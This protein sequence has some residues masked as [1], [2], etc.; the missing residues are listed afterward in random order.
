MA[1]VHE[2]RAQTARAQ[3]RECESAGSACHGS[4][5]FH[6][7]PTPCR[8]SRGPHVPS[9]SSAGLLVARALQ[10]KGTEERVSGAPGSEAVQKPRGWSESRHSVQNTGSR[11]V[12]PNR[13]QA[14]EM[15]LK[16]QNRTVFVGRTSLQVRWTRGT[17]P[18]PQTV[19]SG[20]VFTISW[21]TDTSGFFP[22]PYTGSGY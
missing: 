13:G 1:R 6:R 18:T 7:S 3:Q 8:G 14:S 11:R 21:K 9:L 2:R 12:K 16:N 19:F 4:S 5:R 17:S 22:Q 20:W 15:K 10:P